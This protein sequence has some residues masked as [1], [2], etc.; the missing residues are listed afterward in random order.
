MTGSVIVAGRRIGQV[1][2]AFVQ[3]AMAEAVAY[4]L[5][6][7]LQTLVGPA[8]VPVIYRF[9]S[10]LVEGGSN[11]GGDYYTF[12]VLGYATTV[13][14]TGGLTAFSTQVDLAIQQGRLETYL[15][16]PVSWYTLPFALAGWPILLRLLNAVVVLLLGVAFGA[17]I[18]FSQLPLALVFLTL[19]IAASHAIGVL[20][21]SVLLLSKKADPVVAL[22]TL[23][24]SILS[25]AMFPVE[26]LPR[27]IRVFAYVLPHTYVITAV[28][29]VLMPDGDTVSGPPLTTAVLVLVATVVVLYVLSIYLF[30]RSLEFGRRYGI[31]GGY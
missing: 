14:L 11:V 20:A 2:R 18:Q 9:V 12:V 31:L 28:R 3:L 10:R 19:G 16:Q 13:A 17:R 25:G 26:M 22:Y 24:A 1:T 4:P 27:S 8:S 15:V 7:V 21:A 30:G 5:V 23:A 29:R 6:L